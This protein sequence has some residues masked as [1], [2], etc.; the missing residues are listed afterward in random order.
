PDTVTDAET[1]APLVITSLLNA[2]VEGSKAIISGLVQLTIIWGIV[3]FI[4]MS[5]RQF[6][7][8]RAK[9]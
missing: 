3:Y 9:Q 7:K 1:Y 2:E 4:G 8:T 6:F 5:I